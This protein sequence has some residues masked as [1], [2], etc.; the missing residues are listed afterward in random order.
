MS[1]NILIYAEDV[2]ANAERHGNA[3]AVRAA[4]PRGLH[5]AIADAFAGCGHTVRFSSLEDLDATLTPE[6]LDAADVL[7]WW[8]H[9]RHGDVPDGAAALVA[10]KVQ[11]GL[12]FVALHSAHLAKPFKLLMGTSCT[13]GWRCGESERV[14]VAAPYHP[15]ASGVPPYFD[16]PDEEMY[17]EPF[18]IPSPE[19]TVFIGWFSGG[20]VFRSGL[21][22][23]R[24]WGKVFY[25]QPGHE[26]Y[27]VYCHPTVRLILR[28]AALWAAPAARRAETACPNMP[29]DRPA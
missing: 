4:Y 7:Y 21:T 2:I 13:L 19:D 28:N 18:D 15:I 25:F 17:G 3:D 20:E 6:S 16:L 9:A 22:Y 23:K 26:E 29:P 12:G 10:E 11:A 1:L 24:G 14:W 8:G 27:P 5:A